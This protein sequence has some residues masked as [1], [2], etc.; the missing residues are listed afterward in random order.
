MHL[1]GQHFAHML[2]PPISPPVYL[3]WNDARNKGPESVHFGDGSPLEE[4]HVLRVR[5]Q[6]GRRADAERTQSRYRADTEW[7]TERTQSGRRADAELVQS[8]Y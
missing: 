2:C 1:P 7:I 4:A 3:G 8:G 6:S 5:T